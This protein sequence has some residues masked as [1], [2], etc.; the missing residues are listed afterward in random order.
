[1]LDGMLVLLLTVT[2]NTDMTPQDWTHPLHSEYTVSTRKDLLDLSAIND[3][4]DSD[5]VYWGTRLPQDVLR[6]MLDN[7]LSFGLYYT[8]SDGGESMHL[9]CD[10]C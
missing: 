6:K 9:S 10:R 3:A 1:M 5:M 8:G 2:A 4:L 7:S